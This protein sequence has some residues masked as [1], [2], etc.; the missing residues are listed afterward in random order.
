MTHYDL[1][2]VPRD[3]SE[4]QIK[5]AYKK[6]AFQ[7]HPDRNTDP[8]ANSKFQEINEANEVLSDQVKRI[9]F[10]RQYTSHPLS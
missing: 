10:F 5:K 6:L 9:I 4:E 7:F 2:G 1:L 8:G 3:A